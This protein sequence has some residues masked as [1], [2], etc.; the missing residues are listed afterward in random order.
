MVR[1]GD[2][3]G[4]YNRNFFYTIISDFKGKPKIFVIHD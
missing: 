1:V 2:I 3:N 4:I